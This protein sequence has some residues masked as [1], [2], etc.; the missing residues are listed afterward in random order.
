MGSSLPCL[1][2]CNNA[3]ICWKFA[4]SINQ[5]S[6]R[7]WRSNNPQ[8]PPSSPPPLQLKDFLPSFARFAQM[9]PA[10]QFSK[11]EFS[12]RYPPKGQAQTQTT[13]S[14]DVNNS[15]T[16]ESILNDVPPAAT[17]CLVYHEPDLSQHR[18]NPPIYPIPED[19][20]QY[21]ELKSLQAVFKTI[22]DGRAKC[23]FS[24]MFVRPED[25]RTV[26]GNEFVWRMEEIQKD[27]KTYS[28][29]FPTDP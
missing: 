29:S 4:I 1:E 23:I 7:K 11:A 13:D 20:Q 5:I 26:L 25:V 16:H 14:N 12:V 3:R 8:Q 18:P 21:R 28:Y 10:K 6:Y 17:L 22:P 15:M 9:I 19:F 24:H 27:V 2:Y